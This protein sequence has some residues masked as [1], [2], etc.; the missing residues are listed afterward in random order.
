MDLSE[1]QKLALRTANL[2]RDN[3]LYHLVLGLVG[4]SGEIAEKVKKL[5]RDHESDESKL[6]KQDIAKELGDVLWYLAVLAEY[7]DCDLSEIAKNNIKKLASRQER[8]VLS[9]SGDDR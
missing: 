5:I 1:Y 4:E 9:G 7:L 2:D 6:D 3:E 8:G